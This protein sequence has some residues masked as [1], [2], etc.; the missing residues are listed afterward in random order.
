MEKLTDEVIALPSE[1][2]RILAD[3]LAEN[4]SNDTETTF[5]KNWA[6]EA[7]RRRDEVRSGQVKTVPVDEALAQVR[8]SVSR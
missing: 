8:R 5:H 7:I 4:L 6:T 1:A 2:K 3:R